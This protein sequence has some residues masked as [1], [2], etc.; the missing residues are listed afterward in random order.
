MAHKLA[1]LRAKH[2]AFKD[3]ADGI[4]AAAESQTDGELTNVQEQRLATIKGEILKLDGEIDAEIAGLPPGGNQTTVPTDTRTPAEAEAAERKR[5]ADIMAACKMVGKI[6]RAA[7]FI[8]DGKSLSEVVAALQTERAAA[9]EQS[10]TKPGH[11]GRTADS[12]P[13]PTA[14]TIFANRAKARS[15]RL[16]A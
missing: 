12:K 2:K 3:E 8:A 4:F 16:G 14:A 15:E 6:D 9:S 11:L 7:G 1:D 13:I 5:S 10:V